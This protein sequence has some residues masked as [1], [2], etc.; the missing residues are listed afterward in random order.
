MKIEVCKVCGS[1]PEMIIID[2]GWVGEP[3]FS[4]KIFCGVCEPLTEA[5]QLDVIDSSVGSH[6]EDWNGHQVVKAKG[7]KSA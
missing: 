1:Q 3:Y 4:F 2:D 5:Q 7:K 6:I